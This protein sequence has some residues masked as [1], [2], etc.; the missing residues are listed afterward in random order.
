MIRHHDDFSQLK[1]TVYL[2][3]LIDKLST[4]FESQIDKRRG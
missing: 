3:K 4:S 2:R 1:I